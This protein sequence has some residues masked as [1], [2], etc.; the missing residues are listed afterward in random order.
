MSASTSV[1]QYFIGN[2]LPWTASTEEFLRDEGYE[3]V[4]LLK[5]MEQDEWNQLFADARSAQRRLALK[6]FQ[7]LKAQPLKATDCDTEGVPL[8]EPDIPTSSEKGGKK[9]RN[10][11]HTGKHVRLY[12][13]K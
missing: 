5:L 1:R 3:T 13:K 7:E 8:N 10:H 6:V 4:E 11:T 2:G 12:S 9:K